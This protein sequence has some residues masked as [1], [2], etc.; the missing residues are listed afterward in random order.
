MRY[1]N[2]IFLYQIVPDWFVVD[3]HS[4]FTSPSILPLLIFNVF[5]FCNLRMVT[6]YKHVNM[7]CKNNSRHLNCIILKPVEVLFYF[8]NRVV[9]FAA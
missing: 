3:L 5:S 9:D 8:R 4:C 1:N 7:S 6:E 2:C